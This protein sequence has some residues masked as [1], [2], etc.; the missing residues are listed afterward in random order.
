MEAIENTLGRY[1][2]KVERRDQ[3]TCAR[4]WVEV[5]IKIGLPK[6]INL[7]VADWSHIQELDYEKL[8]FKCRYF[9]EYNHFSQHCK[10]TIEETP[11][12]S[13]GE[14]WKQVQK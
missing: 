11:K 13:K 14:Q 8:P 1:I 10:K 6:S 2:D 3:Y 4:I 9:H 5:D 7:T 12:K